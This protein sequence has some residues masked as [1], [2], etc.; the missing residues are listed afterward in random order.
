MVI[1]KK[2]GIGDSFLFYGI[3]KAEYIR[4]ANISNSRDSPFKWIKTIS[5]LNV[6]I[7]E[8]P[9]AWTIPKARG[10]G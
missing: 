4:S 9:S 8:T 2:F 1:D 6:C 7:R 10:T 3:C 5:L